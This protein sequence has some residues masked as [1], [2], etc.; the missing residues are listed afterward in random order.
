M[1]HKLTTAA[2]TV[3]IL[4][5]L[6]VS[7]GSRDVLMILLD[8]HSEMELFCSNIAVNEES[9]GLIM[10][11]THYAFHLLKQIKDFVSKE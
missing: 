1:S 3:E 4:Y 6:K 5:L 10:R 8:L 7:L 11:E 9:E 2:K